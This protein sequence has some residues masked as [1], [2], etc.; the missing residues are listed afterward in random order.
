[1]ISC[2]VVPG[3]EVGDRVTLW[4]DADSGLQSPES[5]LYASASDSVGRVVISWALRNAALEPHS[6]ESESLRRTSGNCL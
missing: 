1:M 4:A 5:I 6:S 2:S 3:G